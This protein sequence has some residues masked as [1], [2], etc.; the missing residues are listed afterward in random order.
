MPVQGAIPRE[1]FGCA[2]AEN[3]AFSV[4]TFIFALFPIRLVSLRAAV[5]Q[6]DRKLYPALKLG[7]LSLMSA[8]LIE[9]SFIKYSWFM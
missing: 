8:R 5:R 2:S 9:N 3:K 6:T 1:S 4:E 7:R